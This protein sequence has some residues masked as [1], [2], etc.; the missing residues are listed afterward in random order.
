MKN[1]WHYTAE[2]LHRLVNIDPAEREE[3]ERMADIVSRTFERN[4]F[5]DAFK[6]FASKDKEFQQVTSEASRKAA[7]ANVL[8]LS[9]CPTWDELIQAR[10]KVQE[11]CRSVSCRIRPWMQW[12][13]P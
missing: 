1:P 9:E 5:V 4:A 13:K 7:L 6:E 10:D 3:D 2:E 11:L 8:R 12:Q